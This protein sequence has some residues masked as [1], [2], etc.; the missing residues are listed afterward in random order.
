MT[1]GNAAGASAAPIGANGAAADA[2]TC[3]A[4]HAV[5]ASTLHLVRP[6]PANAV[7]V[8]MDGVKDTRMEILV[9]R[10]RIYN[11]QFKS[12]EKAIAMRDAILMRLFFERFA[13]NI[14][15]ERQK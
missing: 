10:Q 3:S 4:A 14:N 15:T 7:P 11:K 2:D 6:N 9:G 8:A 1:A 13:R 5:P 12:L